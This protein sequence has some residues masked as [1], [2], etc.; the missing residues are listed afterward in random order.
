MLFSNKK[1]ILLQQIG[2]EREI[3]SIMKQ[4]MHWKLSQLCMEDDTEWLSQYQLPTLLPTLIKI[5]STVKI[6][7][8]NK[9]NLEYSKNELFHIVFIE[10]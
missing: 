4:E 2:R 6:E 3:S 10:K 9:E 5:I 8:S 1:R 7:P